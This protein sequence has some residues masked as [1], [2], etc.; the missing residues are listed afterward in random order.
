[1]TRFTSTAR[2]WATCLLI[3]AILAQTSAAVHAQKVL[4][5][6]TPFT[7]PATVFLY[8]LARQQVERHFPADAFIS[9]RTTADGRFAVAL[10]GESTRVYDLANGSWFDLPLGFDPR[11]AHP[12]E[13]ALFGLVDGPVSLVMTTGTAARLDATGL[14]RFGGCAAGTVT[15]LSLSGDGRVLVTTCA[16]GDVAILDAAT[17]AVLRMLPLGSG[18]SVAPDF[19]GQR[20]LVA[21]AVA[22]SPVQL[23]D[24]VTG[25]TLAEATVPSAEP[26]IPHVVSASPAGT[27]AIVACQATLGPF[28]PPTTNYVLRLPGLTWGP[29]VGVD[30]FVASISPDETRIFSTFRHR[31]NLWGWVYVRDLATGTPSLT[32]PLLASI[33]VAYPPLAPVLSA[34]VT[35]ARVDL[36]WTLPAASPPAAGYRLDVGSGPGLADITAFTLGA[37]SALVVPAAPAGRYY[38]RLVANNAAGASLPSNELVVDVP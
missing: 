38:V 10:R 1:M 19:G 2:C 14:T 20:L 9:A 33:A 16:S 31:L 7:S 36:Q 28:V 35:G 29:V 15:S 23:V 6:H 34:T 13:I 22:G 21:N 32:A 24:A 5:S 4:V 3:A 30:E 8:D 37:Q 12:R 25:A 11:A 27:I 17:G 18:R 26:C